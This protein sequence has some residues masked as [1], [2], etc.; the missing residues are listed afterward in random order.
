MATVVEGD[1]KAPFSIATISR[2]R[3][4]AIPFPGLPHFTSDPYLIRLSVKQGSIKYHFL[5]LWYDSTW[6]EPKSPGPLAKTLTIMPMIQQLGE[7]CL[8]TD[9]QPDTKEEKQFLR[10]IWELKEHNGKADRIN[11]MEL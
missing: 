1:P 11:N 8:K 4:G 2:C 10:K 9:E 3:E 6:I 7:E 5:S